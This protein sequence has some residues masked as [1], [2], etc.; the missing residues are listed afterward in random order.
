[1][2]GYL[3]LENGDVFEGEKIGYDKSC[4]CEIVFN[5]S[6][7]GHL[8]AFSDPSYRGQGMCMT[9]PLIGLYG[10]PKEEYKKKKIWLEAIF[11]HDLSSVESNSTADITLNDF[12]NEHKI[13]G[14]ANVNTRKLTKILRANGTMKGMLTDDISDLDKIIE[15]ISK[16]KSVKSLEGLSTEEVYCVGKGNIKIALLDYGLIEGV[17]KSLTKKG[18]KITVFPSK[19]KDLKPEEFD[20]IVLPGGPG[21]PA[22]CKEEIELVKKLY[23]SDIPI[24]GIGL[25][26]QLMGLATGAKTDK[27]KYGHRGSNQPVKDLKKDKIHATSQNHGYHIIEETVNKKIAEISHININDKTV[28]GLK[29]IGKDILTVQ[30]QPE[31]NP[32][33]QDSEYIIDDFIKTVKAKKKKK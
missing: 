17:I 29:Y 16:H 12:L 18:C 4:I 20:G 9:Y 25:G 27:L 11:V 26:H 2:K 24:L 8:E 14:L 13:P 7:G 33:P 3:V 6:M 30:F 1:M 5:T 28:E 19:S 21:D 22:D 15:K 23:N 32:G 10:K 31:A